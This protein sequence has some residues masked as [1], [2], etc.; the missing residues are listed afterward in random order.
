MQ[1]YP[2]ALSGIESC[3]P[4]KTGV[5]QTSTAWGETPGL[6]RREAMVDFYQRYGSVTVSRTEKS[7]YH[8]GKGDYTSTTAT[9][10]DCPQ[11]KY[12][13][14]VKESMT[15]HKGM[16]RGGDPLYEVTLEFSVLYYYQAMVEAFQARLDEVQNEEQ[17]RG[18][19]IWMWDEVDGDQFLSLVSPGLQRNLKAFAKQKYVQ[20]GGG[21]EVKYIL[22]NGYTGWDTGD[23]LPW[24]RV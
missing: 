6:A 19:F 12:P 4:S 21:K 24:H 20:Y 14:A 2:G 11:P 23:N 15:P 9:I 5:V 18:F 22:L 8:N 3:R 10:T 7:L 17:L 16:G 13:G 1:A